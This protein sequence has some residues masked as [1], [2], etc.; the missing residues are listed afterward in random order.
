MIEL[1]LIGAGGHA[2]VVYEAA[3][4]TER[5][6]RIFALDERFSSLEGQ[7]RFAVIGS[8]DSLAEFVGDDISWIVALG[9]NSLRQAAFDRLQCL[10]L[11]IAPAIVSSR[12]FCFPGAKL[13]DGTVVF[14]GAIVGPDAVIGSNT[15][16]NTAAVIEHDAQ[17]GSHCHVAPGAVLCGGVV[18]G[19]SAFIGAGAVV[20]PNVA[21]GRG[22]TVGAGAVVTRD[23][24]AGSVVQG[25]PARNISDTECR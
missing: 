5:F 16:I 22:V 3:L 6:S 8:D 23:L 1:A 2:K 12:A 21:V 25:V 10:S 13:G 24:C 17:I 4:S 7:R 19:D 15:I 11:R 14:A 9:D 18:V 20:L